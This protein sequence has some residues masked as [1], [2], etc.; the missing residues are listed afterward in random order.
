MS[1]RWTPPQLNDLVG[2]VRTLDNPDDAGGEPLWHLGPLPEGAVA[3]V[4]VPG[5]AIVLRM[6]GTRS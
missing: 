3:L 6:I 2:Y 1:R 4:V 5:L